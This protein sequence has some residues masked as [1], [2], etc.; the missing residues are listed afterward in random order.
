PPFFFGQSLDTTR[1]EEQHWTR[2]WDDRGLRRGDAAYACQGALENDD[3]FIKRITE[4]ID[5]S[6]CRVA[7]I[8]VG[9]IDQMLHGIVNGTDGLHAGVGHWAQR[10][11]LGRLLD[12]MLEH[13]F[14]VILTAD[15]GN[16]E[17]VGIGK[18]NVGAT[19]DE[20]GERV[21]V[22]SDTLLRSNIG[23]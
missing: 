18:P 13:G 17:G 15:H 7:G 12:A 6:R 16:V 23:E 3:A 22:F 20:R 2:F 5:Q 19:A 21:H 9:T 4:K 11:S 8:V 10:G 1:K 14:E